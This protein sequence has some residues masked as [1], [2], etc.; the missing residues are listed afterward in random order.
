MFVMSFL[1]P[2]TIQA[3]G[4]YVPEIIIIVVVTTLW[5]LDST[6]LVFLIQH[7]LKVRVASFILILLFFMCLGCINTGDLAGSYTDFR[8]LLGLVYAFVISSNRKIDRIVDRYLVYTCLF[9]VVFDTFVTLTRGNDAIKVQFNFFADVILISYYARHGNSKG[10]IACA[11][12]LITQAVFSNYRSYWVVAIIAIIIYFILLIKKQHLNKYELI[13]KTTVFFAIFLAGTLIYLNIDEILAYVP[14]SQVQTYGK[15]NDLLNMIN[16]GNAAESDQVHSQAF[17]I[18]LQ[19]PEIFLIP[20]GLGFKAA[21]DLPKQEV[22]GYSSYTIANTIDCGYYYLAYHFGVFG[23]VFIATIIGIV[24]SSL[25][26]ITN[27]NRYEYICCI[28][29]TSVYLIFTGNLFV[30]LP[31]ALMAGS[32]VGIAWRNASSFHCHG[33]IF[34]K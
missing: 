6:Y 11:L 24:I 19:H 33:N 15:F 29:I 4:L 23:Y 20:H 30:V 2:R 34:K 22:R 3:G 26:L 28:I 14:G 7:T 9:N 21:L 10:F 8:A 31:T 1:G 5:M 13:A 25:I 16:G 32:Y 12:L 17:T 18:T 27:K